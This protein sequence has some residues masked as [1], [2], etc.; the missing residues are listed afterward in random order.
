MF[1]KKIILN[2]IKNAKQGI[3]ESTKTLIID[4]AKDYYED[5]TNN[6]DMIEGMTYCIDVKTLIDNNY[7]NK[8]L[9]D[10][11]LNDIDST[12]KV[13]MIYHNS[14]FDYQIADTCTNNI[15]TRNNIEVPIVTEN[16]GLYKSTTDEDRFI[17]RGGNPIN[18]WIEL[19]EGTSETPNYV[20]YRIVSFE[21]DGTIKVV[22]EESIGN[23]KWDN[24]TD[25]RNTENGY[26]CVKDRGCNVWANINNTYYNGEILNPDF[27]YSFFENNSD[28][29]IKHTSYRGTI[30]QD[31]TMN[32][33]LNNTWLN[34]TNLNP[35]IETHSFNVGSI[36]YFNGYTGGDKGIK[37]EKQEESLYT[38]NGKIGLSSITEYVESSTNVSCTSVYSNFYYNPN[39]VSIRTTTNRNDWP[40]T[41]QSYN[42]MAKGIIEWFI[43]ADA[44][45]ENY[46]Y[47]WEITSDGYFSSY[48]P[49]SPFGVRPAFYLKSSVTL[50]G[51][52]TETN[53]YR[54][55]GES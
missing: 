47:T 53:P 39:N 54:I 48:Y 52:G 36:R 25:R 14:K 51:D 13:K 40:C 34:V 55:A 43:T 19:N 4:A 23:K 15:L 5:N 31:S 8:K 38:W 6:Y 24:S 22:R 28:I 50:T 42:W 45:N 11:N 35:I 12:Q 2:Q 20:K 49:D 37:M 7:L 29:E 26:Y 18:N 32:T 46:Y 17:Y 21:Q 30:T 3:K 1:L 16:S 10:E 27:Y 33:Y 44:I 41:N 9:K